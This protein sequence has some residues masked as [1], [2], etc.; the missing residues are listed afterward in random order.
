MKS[1]AFSL[2]EVMVVVAIIALIAAFGVPVLMDN[3]CRGDMSEVQSC[4]GDAALRLDNYR[5][6][7]GKYPASNQWAALGYDASKI[8]GDAVICGEHYKGNFTVPAGGKSYAVVFADTNAKLRCSDNAGD[9][10]WTMTNTSPK[11][12]HTKNPLGAAETLP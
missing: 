1:N 8:D 6:N 12:Y 4:I 10:E 3:L 7:H 9:D 2:I 11:V 5:S